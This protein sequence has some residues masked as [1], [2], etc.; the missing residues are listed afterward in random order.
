MEEWTL[1][2]RAPEE[3]PFH[4]HINAF[5]VMSVNGRPYPAHG[6]QDV[7]TIPRM[8]NGTPG[9]V[10]IRIP[11]RHFTGHFVFHCHILGHEDAGMMMTVQVRRKGEPVTPPPTGLTVQHALHTRP[12]ATALGAGDTSPAGGVADPPATAWLCRLRNQTAA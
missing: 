12:A 6:L 7:V 10:V 1:R 11:F 4:I 9:E 2:N 5:Q 8:R 3:H